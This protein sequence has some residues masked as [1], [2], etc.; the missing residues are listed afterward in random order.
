MKNIY[1]INLYIIFFYLNLTIIKLKNIFYLFLLNINELFAKKKLYVLLNHTERRSL[2]KMI[3]IWARYFSFM[4][5][6]IIKFWYIFNTLLSNKHRMNKKFLKVKEIKVSSN[7]L[8]SYHIDLFEKNKYLSFS[9]IHLIS[10][11]LYICFF[12]KNIHLI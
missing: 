9:V 12:I 10:L 3:Q 1:L 7:F 4:E 6:L 8:I 11:K 2:H 5:I